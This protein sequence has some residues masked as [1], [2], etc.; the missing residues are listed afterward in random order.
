MSGMEYDFYQKIGPPVNRLVRVG[1]A[2]V[3]DG[4]PVWYFAAKPEPL[5]VVMRHDSAITQPLI[6]NDIR[7][8]RS[9]TIT[10]DIFVA[11]VPVIHSN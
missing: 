11:N 10:G 4:R 7:Y 3:P 6:N 8:E 9:H 2:F 5:Q 1:K